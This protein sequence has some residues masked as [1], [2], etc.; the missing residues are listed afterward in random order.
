MQKG[1]KRG[2]GDGEQ[3]LK[4][5]DSGDEGRMK[6]ESKERDIFV[7]EPYEVSKKLSTRE[8]HR[9]PQE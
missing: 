2:E 9:N 8:I 4:K 6:M 1:Q 7:T 3:N 5:W